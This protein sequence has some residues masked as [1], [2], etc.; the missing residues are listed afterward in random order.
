MATSKLLQLPLRGI[1]LQQVEQAVASGHYLSA[2][3]VMRDALRGLFRS[4]VGQM[5]LE[6]GQEAQQAARS[7][8]AATP[9]AGPDEPPKRKPT[10][11]EVTALLADNEKAHGTEYRKC[12]NWKRGCTIC[13]ARFGRA[14]GAPDLGPPPVGTVVRPRTGADA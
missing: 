3:E 5:A 8:Q 12:S 9:E 11:A 14:P 2:A 1:L 10:M 13:S 6:A 7:I 4:E